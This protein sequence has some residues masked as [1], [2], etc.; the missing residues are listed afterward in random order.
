MAENNEIIDE[1]FLE[2]E[3]T[4]EKAISHLKQELLAIS[5]S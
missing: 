2:F 1:I 4:Q 5:I 3:D